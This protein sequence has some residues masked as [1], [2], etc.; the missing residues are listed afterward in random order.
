MSDFPGKPIQPAD[1]E[2]VLM[3]IPVSAQPYLIEVR[4]FYHNGGMTVTHR[5]PTPEE[6]ESIRA[7]ENSA[8]VNDET[9]TKEE[10]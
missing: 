9:P 5:E 4:H 1:E 3:D 6:L 2:E 7:V 8:P 10:K